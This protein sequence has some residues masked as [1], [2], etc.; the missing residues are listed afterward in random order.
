MRLV[1]SF[2]K[3]GGQRATTR[4]QPTLG[5]VTLMIVILT[6]LFWASGMAMR[7]P[8]PRRKRP[9]ARTEM[10]RFNRDRF[11][12]KL[13]NTLN[14]AEDEAFQVL[15]W[16]VDRLQSG[17]LGQARRFLHFPPQVVGGH[18]GDRYFIPPWEMETLLNERLTLPPLQLKP[19][20][21]NRVMNCREFNA[22]ATAVN[23]LRR[24]ENAEFRCLPAANERDAGNA[25][26]R[27]S[28]V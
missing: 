16:A 4:Q 27:P 24:L 12:R 26:H 15:I 19:N 22:L 9:A 20:A 10:A 11:R 13:D 25:P 17:D 21:P 1:S 14:R 28:P 5:G 7:Q 2:F 18:L 3:P 8:I 6:I 23:L